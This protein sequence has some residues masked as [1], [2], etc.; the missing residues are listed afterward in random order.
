MDFIDGQL[1]RD[2]DP[3]CEYLNPRI[4]MKSF[5]GCALPIYLCDGADRH[6][7]NYIIRHDSVFF[8]I[9]FFLEGNRNQ[10]LIVME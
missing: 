7:E 4:L 10:H 2:F 8:A 5:V 3:S 9:D 6:Y 1:L